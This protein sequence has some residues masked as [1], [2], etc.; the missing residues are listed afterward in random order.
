MCWKLRIQEKKL[1]NA[2][3]KKIHAHL[4]LFFSVKIYQKHTEPWLQNPKYVPNHFC[5]V[6]TLEHTFIGS[7]WK[8][9]AEI[10]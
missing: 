9:G 5:N 1:F 4:Y 6:K 7:K 3:E 2:D 10:P 8:L